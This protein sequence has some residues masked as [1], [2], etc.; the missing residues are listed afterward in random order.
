L[1]E[2]TAPTRASI[3]AQTARDREKELIER[4]FK[5]ARALIEEGLSRLKEL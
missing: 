5:A 3:Q 2:K 1:I 4:K